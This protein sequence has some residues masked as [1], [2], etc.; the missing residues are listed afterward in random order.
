[1]QRVPELIYKKKFKREME[2]LPTLFQR[3]PADMNVKES[4]S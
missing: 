1:M 3:G 4:A 2:E